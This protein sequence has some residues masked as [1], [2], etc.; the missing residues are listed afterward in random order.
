VVALDTIVMVKAVEDV[1]LVTQ[2]VIILVVVNN[3]YFKIE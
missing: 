1:V 2:Q 3:R